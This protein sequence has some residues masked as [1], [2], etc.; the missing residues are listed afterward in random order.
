MAEGEC[1][2][3]QGSRAVVSPGD[4][5][6]QT[7]TG[8]VEGY[9]YTTFM[10]HGS[11]SM[12]PSTSAP[13]AIIIAS[14]VPA[15]TQV[16]PAAVLAELQDGSSLPTSVLQP[17]PGEGTF[18][19]EVRSSSCVPQALIMTSQGLSCLPGSAN[20]RCRHLGPAKWR[21]VHKL[22]LHKW[23][24]PPRQCCAALPRRGHLP[25]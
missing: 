18:L 14:L 1:V 11:G 7:V 19:I 9:M 13:S 12:H 16:P 10:E 2:Q 23:Q 17:Y 20:D 8:A 6:N 22:D 25:D 21:L 24:L 4:T 3:M 5:S 15:T